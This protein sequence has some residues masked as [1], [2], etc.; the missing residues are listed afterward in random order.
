MSEAC[1]ARTDDVI[2]TCTDEKGIAAMISRCGLKKLKR[3]DKTIAHVNV[4]PN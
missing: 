1:S 4:I 2:L 3:Q